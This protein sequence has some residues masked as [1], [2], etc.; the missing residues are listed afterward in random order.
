MRKISVELPVDLI[1]KALLYA[2]S[3]RIY[4]KFDL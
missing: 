2:A 1:Q 3:A 4:R